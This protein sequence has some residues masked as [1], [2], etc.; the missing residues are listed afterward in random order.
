MKTAQLKW[1]NKLK[2]K[3]EKELNTSMSWLVA[4]ILAEHPRVHTHTHV[5][6]STTHTY[7]HQPQAHRCHPYLHH[8]HDM[9]GI[10]QVDHSL[11]REFEPNLHSKSHAKGDQQQVLAQTVLLR[12][13]AVFPDH[14]ELLGE[15][16]LPQR[17]ADLHQG[18]EDDHQTFTDALLGR[19]E[20]GAL[21][22]PVALKLR[23]HP[24]VDPVQQA[25]YVI[26]G[27]IPLLL[28]EK[29]R[30]RWNKRR[31]TDFLAK[32]ELQD[33]PFVVG[34]AVER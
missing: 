1:I 2:H 20:G 22:A 3:S 13:C 6:L 24:A 31:H 32:H 11:G 19:Q 10:Q 18:D 21:G 33:F 23:V 28:L 15:V 14:P 26:S 27:H 25:V 8:G 9:A 17:H 12:P 16:D 4:L 29:I 7:R 30:T 5:A 34:L